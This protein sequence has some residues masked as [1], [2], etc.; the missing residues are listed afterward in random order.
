MT[1]V[2]LATAILVSSIIGYLCVLLFTRNT[3]K[4]HG[5][6]LIRISLGIGLGY[7]VTSV[8]CFL[9]RVVIGG[10]DILY[11]VCE[12]IFVITLCGVIRRRIKTEE[13]PPSHVF[14]KEVELF[15]WKSFL[16][17]SLAFV[18]LLGII[19]FILATIVA[20]SGMWDA[21][22]VQ[23]RAARFFYLGGDYW[24][25]AFS[26]LLVSADYPPL[27][28][29]SV[30]RLWYYTG[31]ETVFGPILFA[32]TITFALIGL[33]IG[34][35]TYLRG[36]AFAYLAGLVLLT[37][38]S[39]LVFAPA[40][41]ADIPIAFYFLATMLLLRIYTENP[42]SYQLLLSLAGI[43]SAMA[44]WTKNEGWLFVFAI[45]T[46]Y[47]LVTLVL[48]KEPFRKEFVLPFLSGLLPMIF[49]VFFFK[50]GF[51]PAH[52]F[53]RHQSPDFS[54]TDG[55]LEPHRY[56]MIAGGY[57]T[58]LYDLTPDRSSPLVV[59]FFI[60]LLFGADRR[61]LNNARLFFSFFTLILIL[62]GEFA[63]Y[64]ITPNDLQWQISSSIHR[65]FLQIWPVLVFEVMMLVSPRS[66]IVNDRSYTFRVS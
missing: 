2:L 39:L 11:L 3:P 24:T 58:Q 31:S 17:F 1:I 38:S 45:F 33:F 63:I 6:F 21:W 41:L 30:A 56:S 53:L 55:L 5:F 10:F 7:G 9:W 62:I 66:F 43:N 35:V 16:F 65:L 50:L 20:P 15:G 27:V 28:G 37:S 48:R 54:I 22:M 36:Q 23:N 32:F 42:R 44:V 40:Q 29:M 12:F 13:F 25:N 64:L 49:V 61:D 46:A 60:V 52:D 14:P 59:L 26:P 57:L 8:F 19:T 51:T 4:T 18:I 34:A 47:L